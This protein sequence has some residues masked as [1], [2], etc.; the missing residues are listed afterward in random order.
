MLPQRPMPGHLARARCCY[1]PLWHC[2][3]A[4]AAAR[5]GSHGPHRGPRQGPTRR[6]APAGARRALVRLRQRSGHPPG[7]ACVLAG[8][9]RRNRFREVYAGQNGAPVV[10]Y[11][12]MRRRQSP[13]HPVQ[14]HHPHCQA[15][16]A[17]SGVW[18]RRRNLPTSRAWRR[19][20]NALVREGEDTKRVFAR[21]KHSIAFS[22]DAA[23]AGSW[24]GPRQA[25]AILGDDPRLRMYGG[26]HEACKLRS[27]RVCARSSWSRVSEKD[28][29]MVNVC[30]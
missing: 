30:P 29:L 16:G 18:G 6:R 5:V 27:V 8:A 28:A 20:R 9:Q 12:P 17:A 14:L 23:I 4:A 7:I 25:G 13:L 26:S 11:R 24:S 1:H 3:E 2:S 10:E 19:D 21:A 22:R 15:P